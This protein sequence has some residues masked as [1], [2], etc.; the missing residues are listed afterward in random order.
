MIVKPTLSLPESNRRADSR[1]SR[2]SNSA[3]TW[4]WFS[5]TT[6]IR[7]IFTGDPLQLR[8]RQQSMKK[9][10]GTSTVTTLVS[11]HTTALSCVAPVAFSILPNWSVMTPLYT[12]SSFVKPPQQSVTHVK[13][14]K[15]YTKPHLKDF[16]LF[17]KVILTF[18]VITNIREKHELRWSCKWACLYFT[19]AYTR[20][21]F[22][23]F[24]GKKHA[25]ISSVVQV[26]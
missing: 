25:I 14:L 22:L 5:G 6:G 24:V 23:R 18:L 16:F 3:S 13:T 4:L 11:L 10:K 2:Q 19:H 9:C 15:W 20:F 21:C 8:D 17:S 7:D 1:G 12:I 26:V